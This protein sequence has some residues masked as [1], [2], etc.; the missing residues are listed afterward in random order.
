MQLPARALRTAGCVHRPC[1]PCARQPAGSGH[2]EAGLTRAGP[3]LLLSLLALQWEAQQACY[4]QIQKTDADSCTVVIEQPKTGKIL[5]MAQWPAYSATGAPGS[6]SENLAVQDVFEPGSTAKVITAAAAMEKGGQSIT[7]TYTVPDT[8]NE[9]G[10]NFRDA[11]NHPVMRWTMLSGMQP[12][13]CTIP[14]I[15]PNARSASRLTSRIAI[16]SVTSAG[17]T[18]T[19][20]PSSRIRIAQSVSAG[21]ADRPTST[22]LA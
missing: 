10:F 18:R 19:S 13:A 16:R 3:R 14:L 21:N 15:G 4:Q 7:S 20:P 17:N 22:S 12:A 11:E 1:L 5:A 8:I 6:T 9:D 2:Q